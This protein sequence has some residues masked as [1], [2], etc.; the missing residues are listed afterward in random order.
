VLIFGK[1]RRP[2]QNFPLA[3]KVP[4][5]FPSDRRVLFRVAIKPPPVLA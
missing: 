3:R 1:V 4:P 5:Q 2:E